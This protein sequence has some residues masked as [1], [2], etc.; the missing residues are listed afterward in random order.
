MSF[1]KVQTRR[2]KVYRICRTCNESDLKINVN[3]NLMSML[4]FAL[5]LRSIFNEKYDIHLAIFF[6]PVAS[7]INR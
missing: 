5:F 3:D 7:N 1:D 2:S 4:G 6:M